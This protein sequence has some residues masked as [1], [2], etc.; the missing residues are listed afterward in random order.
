MK[1]TEIPLDTD[2]TAEEERLAF[3]AT[4]TDRAAVQPSKLWR[5]NLRL[6]VAAATVLSVVRRSARARARGG[7]DH[8][9]AACG[10]SARRRPRCS[11]RTGSG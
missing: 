11:M 5:L 7:E 4:A 1:L 9:P 3:E 6:D 2:V 10:A 8:R